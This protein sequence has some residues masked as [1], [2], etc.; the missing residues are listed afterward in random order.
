MEAIKQDA[1]IEG[2]NLQASRWMQD[3]PEMEPLKIYISF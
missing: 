2:G 3:E 1:S